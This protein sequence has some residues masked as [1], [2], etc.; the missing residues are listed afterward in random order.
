MKIGVY[1]MVADILHTVHVI[2]IEEAKKQCDYLIVALHCCP[3]YKNPVQTIYERYMQLRAIKYVDEVI[4]YENINDVENMLRSLCFD[5]Y[6][7]GED[8]KD[9]DWECRDVVVGL[10]KEIV[11]LSRQH[12]YSS[13]NLKKRIVSHQVGE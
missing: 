12:I 1:P 2:A 10:G 9:K 11:Y 4:P 13:T 3:N 5:I 7:L 6:F 8:Y